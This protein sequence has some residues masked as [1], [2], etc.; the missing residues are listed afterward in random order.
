MCKSVK[1]QD[2]KQ[3]FWNQFYLYTNKKCTKLRVEKEY[4]YA[5]ENIEE[6]TG[7]L[8]RS[9]KAQERDKYIDMMLYYLWL[10]YKEICN[11]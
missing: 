3:Q 7:R 1:W 5:Y 11:L 10:Y 2:N 4:M 6:K 9:S 8:K